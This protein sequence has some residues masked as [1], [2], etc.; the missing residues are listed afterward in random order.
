MDDQPLSLDLG[1][2]PYSR[3]IIFGDNRLPGYA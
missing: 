1:K 3:A 2:A